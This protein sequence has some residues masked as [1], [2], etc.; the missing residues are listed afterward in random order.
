[1]DELHLLAKGLLEHETLSG[2]EIKQVIRGEPVVRNRPDEPVPAGRG[3]VPSSGRPNPRP[4][5]GA[6]GLGPAPA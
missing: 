6:G 5:P 2:D 1:M 3:S 4:E